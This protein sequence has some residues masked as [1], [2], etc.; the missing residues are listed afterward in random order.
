MKPQLLYAAVW[1][2]VMLVCIIMSMLSI[3]ACSSINT[4]PIDEAVAFLD[5][6]LTDLSNQSN[7]WQT[8]ALKYK[9]ELDKLR[10]DARALIK[11]DVPYAMDR[12]TQAVAVQTFCGVD[13]VRG[14]LYG[15]LTRIRERLLKQTPMPPTPPYGCLASPP[16]ADLNKTDI[17]SI[18]INGYDF[19]FG[20]TTK[21]KLLMNDGKEED[22]TNLKGTPTHYQL[23]IDISNTTALQN[24]S[25]IR[26]LW[27]N[28]EEISR[29]DIIPVKPKPI[30]VCEVKPD[31][32]V[33][34]QT[35]GIVPNVLVHGDAE[36]QGHGPKI[37]VIAGTSWV[38]GHVVKLYQAMN[39]DEWTDDLPGHAEGDHSSFR[40]E[41]ESS[42]YA[43]PPGWI[44][45]GGQNIDALDGVEFIHHSKDRSE[46]RGGKDLVDYWEVWGDSGNNDLG[47]TRAETHVRDF[48]VAI[49]QE[50]AGDGGP[51]I[52]PLALVQAQAQG[53]LSP[54]A[55]EAYGPQ[56][57]ALSEDV[58]TQLKSLAAGK[59]AS[60]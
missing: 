3:A 30:P 29:I 22:W 20:D 5:R 10:T 60:R 34:G 26:V 7:D 28:K 53:A 33:A 41:V 52:S 44:I 2:R 4:K 58:R 32:K 59:G 47:H 16:I 15:D 37:W 12:A 11:D 21:I 54:A 17:N 45:F 39:A 49:M 8:I 27:N 56:L 57:N 51:C 46:K 38:G 35:V 25:K 36:F 24:A 50:K 43:T 18:L 55:L 6:L 31:V 14:R 40:G 1:T 9:D 19:D 48:S 13:F 23:T 42:L